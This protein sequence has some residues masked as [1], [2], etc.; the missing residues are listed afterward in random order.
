MMND[1]VWYQNSSDGAVNTVGDYDI[2]EVLEHL[3]HTIHLTACLVQLPVHKMP[4]SG[5][6][7]TTG[8][9]NKRTLLRHERGGRQRSFQ[10]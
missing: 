1:M 7:N 5:I 4:F 9:A 6:Q 2:A 10:P 8:L 3:M